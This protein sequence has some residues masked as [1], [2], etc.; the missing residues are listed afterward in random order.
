MGKLLFSNFASLVSLIHNFLSPVTEFLPTNSVKLGILS[1]IS[2]WR[3]AAWRVKLALVKIDR[4]AMVRLVS[5]G[6]FRMTV[7]R[8]ARFLTS[9]TG[10]K[11]LAS[12]SNIGYLVRDT[13]VSACL[14][15]RV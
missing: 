13:R 1:M 15:D 11:L 9:M 6:I 4:L 12:I 8:S 14:P 10:A 3:L 5:L 2:Y 7:D